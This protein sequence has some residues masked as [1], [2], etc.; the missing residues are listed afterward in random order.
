MQV[1]KGI[2]FEVCRRVGRVPGHQTL[3]NADL[4]CGLWIFKQFI[5]S[6]PITHLLLK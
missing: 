4:I 2:L 5:I 6:H 3:P 1:N